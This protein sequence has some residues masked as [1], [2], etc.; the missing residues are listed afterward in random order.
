M[1]TAFY[2]MR[3][4]VDPTEKVTI[5][6]KGS[7]NDTLVSVVDKNTNGTLLLSLAFNTRISP[8]KVQ[9]FICLLF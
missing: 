5:P 7:V 3:T 8:K 4:L 6:K 1:L 9:M 2:I